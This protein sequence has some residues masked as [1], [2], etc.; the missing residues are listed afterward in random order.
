MMALRRL[1]PLLRVLWVVWLLAFL[2]SLGVT[3]W[4]FLLGREGA[5][6]S[7]QLYVVAWA[8]LELGL[9]C[10]WPIGAYNNTRATPFR[11][12]RRSASWLDSRLDSWR[13]QLAA[14]FVLAVLPIACIAVA[15]SASPGSPLFTVAL[16]LMVLGMCVWLAA[17]YWALGS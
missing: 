9:A 13:G 7:S 1:P 11:R 4:A 6:S 2:A 14:A 17:T 3:T 12:P 16:A 8:L 10:N 15:L 5:K